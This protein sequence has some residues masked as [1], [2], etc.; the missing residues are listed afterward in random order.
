MTMTYDFIPKARRDK[1]FLKQLKKAL[2][3]QSESIIFTDIHK[4]SFYPD[5]QAVTVEPKSDTS[6][7]KEKIVPKEISYQA[8]LHMLDGE[9]DK[10][11]P[12]DIID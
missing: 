5:K 9:W 12:N 8:V 7:F 1:A 4:L 11:N 2:F 6:D 3:S 10:I